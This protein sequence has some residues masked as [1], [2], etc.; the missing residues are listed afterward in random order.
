MRYEL[1]KN[2]IQNM[3]IKGRGKIIIVNR[4]TCGDV[5]DAQVGDELKVDDRI[6]NITALDKFYKLL[7]PPIPGDNIGFIVKEKK[8]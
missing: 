5:F 2:K 4:F 1:D 3:T 7:S 8:W 6:Y